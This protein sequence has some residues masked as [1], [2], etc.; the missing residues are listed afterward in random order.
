MHIPLVL[1]WFG[2]NYCNCL[3]FVSGYPTT[4]PIAVALEAREVLFDDFVDDREWQDAPVPKSWLIFLV[5][6]PGW[7]GKE[8]KMMEKWMN[9]EIYGDSPLASGNFYLNMSSSGF[10]FAQIQTTP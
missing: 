2:W 1:G 4:R 9:M 6:G 10:F 5:L 8:W 3:I 7:V